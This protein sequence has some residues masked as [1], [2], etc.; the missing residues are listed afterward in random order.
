MGWFSLIY[1]RL[2]CRLCNGAERVER[3]FSHFWAEQ[4]CHEFEN[5]LFIDYCRRFCC[6][7]FT[8]NSVYFSSDEQKYVRETVQKH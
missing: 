6:D 3:V 1:I 2:G 7:N 5:M 8:K 4:T